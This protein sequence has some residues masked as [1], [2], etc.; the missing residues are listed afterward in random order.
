MD[1]LRDK[2]VAVKLLAQERIAVEVQTADGREF[3]R[4]VVLVEPG[5]VTAD[6]EGVALGENLGI[7][8][9]KGIG[10]ITPRVLVL[11]C[12]MVEGIRVVAAKPI[13]PVV[14]RAPIL[15]LALLAVEPARIRVEAEVMAAQAQGVRALD[16]GDF[17]GTVAVRAVH[18]VV[19]AP[20]EPVHAVL[21]VSLAETRQR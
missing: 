6:G 16:R 1:G 4:V 14:H 17:P 20:P 18:P 10:R 15:R 13:A 3:V 9:V 11:Q 7:R 19:Q 8:A 12:E 2:R 5:D 21:L